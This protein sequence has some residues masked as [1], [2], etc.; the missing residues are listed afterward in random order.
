MK[1]E[2][3]ILFL[4]LT[5]FAL[6]CTDNSVANQE[7]YDSVLVIGELGDINFDSAKII[8]A[9]TLGDTV[10]ATN[11]EGREYRISKTVP[12]RS[13]ADILFYDVTKTTT[14][15]AARTTSDS[16]GIWKVWIPP[17]RYYAF[18]VFFDPKTFTIET[19]EGGEFSV[20]P[21]E[22]IQIGPCIG[23]GEK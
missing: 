3:I 14:S 9:D 5:G 12:P 1:I 20:S 8:P 4:F 6:N 23:C 15:I 22:R 11:L 19:L 21:H 10:V 17:G 2:N 13:G 18:A 16:T 7:T